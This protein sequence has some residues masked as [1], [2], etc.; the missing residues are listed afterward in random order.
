MSGNF[1]ALVWLEKKER[2]PT[3]DVLYTILRNHPPTKIQQ[4]EYL[5]S[6]GIITEQNIIDWPWPARY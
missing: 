3:H 2:F 5:V 1:E 6:K 4:L